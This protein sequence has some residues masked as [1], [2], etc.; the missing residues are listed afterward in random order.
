MTYL[1][2]LWAYER[3][4]VLSLEQIDND[5]V[6]ALLVSLPGSLSVLDELLGSTTIPIGI[7]DV[8]LLQDA[9]EI[10]VQAVKEECEE[11][12]SVM[13]RISAELGCKALE[14]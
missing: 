2:T 1:V 4:L 14:G 9:V 8:R 13:L 10:F 3:T 11:L 6:I 7:L 12:L 5:T